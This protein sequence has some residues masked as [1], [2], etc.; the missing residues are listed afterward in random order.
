MKKDSGWTVAH[1]AAYYNRLPEE[2]DR[3]DLVDKSGTTVRK[4][5]FE[6]WLYKG[7]RR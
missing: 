1:E 3:L 5:A 6:A 4:V 7:T 2:F